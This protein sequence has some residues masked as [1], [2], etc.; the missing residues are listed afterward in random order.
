MKDKEESPIK[1]LIA[2]QNLHN[3]MWMLLTDVTRRVQV[4]S[5]SVKA[6]DTSLLD[7]DI[8]W[9][10]TSQHEFL[11]T[12]DAST[13]EVS[14]YAMLIS[15][16]SRLMVDKIEPRLEI[17]TIQ[18]ILSHVHDEFTRKYKA[19]G[20]EMHLPLSSVE[21]YV[22][23]EYFSVAIKM[24]LEALSDHGRMDKPIHLQV[25][26]DNENLVLEVEDVDGNYY[27]LMK[28][29]PDN[30]NPQYILESKLSSENII[31]CFIAYRL[32]ALQKIALNVSTPLKGKKAIRLIIPSVY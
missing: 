4:S 3:S 9:D 21:V 11:T 28:G 27:E 2:K 20:F 29:F 1:E 30:L 24:L 5:A 31:M 14:R 10:T 15:F 13:D 7:Y 16:T 23:F 18:E 32:C 17:Q 26:P 8:F 19:I 22:D 6:A 12:I 25:Y